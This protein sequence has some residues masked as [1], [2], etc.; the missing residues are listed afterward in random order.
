MESFGCKETKLY[1]IPIS[2][3]PG[4]AQLLHFK[5]NSYFLIPKVMKSGC[6]EIDL[7]IVICSNFEFLGIFKK[8]TFSFY[9]AITFFLK[10]TAREFLQKEKALA[11]FIF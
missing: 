3:Q 10:K 9:T 7:K 4:Y 2:L 1:L 8:H 6:K 11:G 5:Q